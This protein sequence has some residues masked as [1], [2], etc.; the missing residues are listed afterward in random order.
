MSQKF[1]SIIVPVF[2]TPRPLLVSCFSSIRR[3]TESDWELIVIDDGSSEECANIIDELCTDIPNT[4]VKH[5]E[6]GG[7]SSARNLGMTVAR[8]EWFLFVDS[9]D[10]LPYDAVDIYKKTLLCVGPEKP[11]DMVIGLSARGYRDLSTGEDRITLPADETDGNEN[12]AELIE[13]IVDKDELVNHILTNRV[14]RWNF[15]SG[16][17]ADGPCGKLY[18]NNH[19]IQVKFPTSLEWSEDTV[20][21][22]QTLLT[23][24]NILLIK[25]RTYNAVNYSQSATRRFRNNCLEEFRKVGIAENETARFFPNCRDSFAYD[26]FLDVLFVA[27]LYFF[28]KDNPYSKKENYKVF[29]EWMKREETVQVLKYAS[30]YITGNAGHSKVFRLL[31]R[32]MLIAPIFFSWWLLKKYCEGRA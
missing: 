6:N 14:S 4:I 15:T 20:W 9:D 5:K 23:C 31:A 8:G 32:F 19:P 16:Y 22:L 21:Y 17:F 11:V 27:R 29:C 26:R 10:T 3:Q 30:C 1:V 12:F 18:R 2:N 24:G 13:N 28:H 7:V 25:K